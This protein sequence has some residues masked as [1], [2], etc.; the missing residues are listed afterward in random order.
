MPVATAVGLFAELSEAF[1]VVSMKKGKTVLQA[2]LMFRWRKVWLLTYLF[3]HFKSD[4]S[5]TL[6][7]VDNFAATAQL[8]LRGV[9]SPDKSQKRFKGKG[10]QIKK[11]C[12]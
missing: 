5:Q 3:H 12:Q 1:N 2:R 8:S 7:G 6:L 9:C 11:I 10:G 4:S